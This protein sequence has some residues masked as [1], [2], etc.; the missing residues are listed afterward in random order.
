[1]AVA[2]APIPYGRAD[3]LAVA[4]G[5]LGAPV[6]LV[7]CKTIPLEVPAN[8]EIVIEGLMSTEVT[9]PLIPFGEYPGHLQTEE[10][11][12]PVIQVTAITHRKGAIFT[13]ITVGMFPS[14][15]NTILGFVYGAT[16]YHHLRYGAGFPVGGREFCL[17]RLRRQRGIDPWS[18]L[19]A[20]AGLMGGAK[21]VIVVDEDIDVRD[22]DAVSWALSYRF[23]PES[24]L[25]LAYGRAP[26]LDP[27]AIPPGAGRGE[28]VYGASLLQKQQGKLLINAMRKWGYP[29]VCLPA[30]SY[31]ERALA[32]WSK[33]QELPQPKLREPW[34]GYELGNWSEEN[35]EQARLIAEGKYLEVGRRTGERQRR[36]TTDMIRDDLLMGR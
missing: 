31:M 25:E 23:R 15:N 30:Q 12:L 4:G 35:R 19:H 6:E 7:R 20:A 1:M 33:H 34:Y 16:L 10:T 32:I 8:A 36:V 29:P 18:V 27:S 17:I 11:Y 2:S 26:S 24:D 14:D 13:P 9:E 22:P 28:M 3:E 21:F 5:I